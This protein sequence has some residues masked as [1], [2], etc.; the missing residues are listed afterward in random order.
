MNSKL[1]EQRD[2][3]RLPPSKHQ[4]NTVRAAAPTSGR[5]PGSGF[6]SACEFSSC[7]TSVCQGGGRGGR[8]GP[9]HGR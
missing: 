9:S 8:T 2:E 5:R 1:S 4:E 3:E 6:S 7:L